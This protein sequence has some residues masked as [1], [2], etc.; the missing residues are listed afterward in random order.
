MAVTSWWTSSTY[1]LLQLVLIQL[2]P[3][4]SAGGH[5]AGGHSSWWRSNNYFLLPADL[6]LAQSLLP[7]DGY[8]AFNLLLIINLITLCLCRVKFAALVIV[9]TATAQKI[10]RLDTSLTY[11]DLPIIYHI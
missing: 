7:A 11:S 9:F 8:P 5:S 10:S 2:I 6:F 3:P 1:F 4:L